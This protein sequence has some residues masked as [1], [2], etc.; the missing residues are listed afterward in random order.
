M[1]KKRF[2]EKTKLASQTLLK[3]Q[4][5]QRKSLFLCGFSIFLKTPTHE[6]NQIQAI[7]TKP[8]FLSSNK[9]IVNLFLLSIV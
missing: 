5:N 1:F 7:W 6:K 8:T 9:V 4:N 3:P 2:E